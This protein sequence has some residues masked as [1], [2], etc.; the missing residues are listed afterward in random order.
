MF[1][2][3]FIDLGPNVTVTASGDVPLVILSRTSILWRTRLEIVP[4]TLGG[5]TGWGTGGGGAN[6][7][8]VNDRGGLGSGTRAIY[9]H[10][11]TLQGDDI[12]EIQ[13]WTTTVGDGEN[14]GGY[15]TLVSKMPDVR[16]Q[17]APRIRTNEH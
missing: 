3:I 7:T 8:G 13:T 9:S 16:R 2:F 11:L 17:R 6:G 1:N 15:Y 10:T 12:D 5:W 4:G 14:L